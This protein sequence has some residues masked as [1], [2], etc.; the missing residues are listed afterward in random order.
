MWLNAAFGALYD[1]DEML[2][3]HE[4]MT[5]PIG[6]CLSVRPEERKG[7]LYLPDIAGSPIR[8]NVKKLEE[9]GIIESIRYFDASSTGRFSVRAA[10]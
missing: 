2:E 5:A 8:L 1:E 6:E 10:Y 3:N 7:R 4:P 9:E